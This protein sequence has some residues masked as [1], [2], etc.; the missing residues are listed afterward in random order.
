MI[1]WAA[2]HLSRT[3]EHVYNLL[4]LLSSCLDKAAVD[5]I[6]YGRAG[7]LYCLLFVK[8]HI[9][10]EAGDRLELGKAAQQVFDALMAAGK[11][12]SGVKPPKTG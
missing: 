6:L 1:Y 8:K 12:N 7:Y 4:S 2:G 10:K 9:S 11:R 3:E 5:E